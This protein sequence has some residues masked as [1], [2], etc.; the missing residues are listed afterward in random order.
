MSELIKYDEININVNN[1]NILFIKL[2]LLK[3]L[4]EIYELVNKL[5]INGLF[6]KKIV[7]KTNIL[8][9]KCINININN[10]N[11]KNKNKNY[12]ISILEFIIKYSLP[13]HINK[14][15]FSYKRINDLTF[16]CDMTL[17]HIMCKYKL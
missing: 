4:N 3:N 6:K 2:Y 1:Y 9:K 13:L 16:D 15:F 7:L 14:R 8:T 17:L 11:D 12:Q 10:I 5:L